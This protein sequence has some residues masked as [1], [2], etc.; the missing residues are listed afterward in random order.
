MILWVCHKGQTTS[1][2]QMWPP[3]K[4]A[5]IYM[6][7]ID[8][9]SKDL[10]QAQVSPSHPS[11]ASHDPCG[12][13]IEKG[14]HAK[15]GHQP[16]SHRGTECS[17]GLAQGPANQHFARLASPGGREGLTLKALRHVFPFP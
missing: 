15:A 1:T 5:D 7:L 9:G 8:I 6:K 14:L 10:S 17:T 16:L 2:S 12:H 13:Y 4:E 11:P 3:G